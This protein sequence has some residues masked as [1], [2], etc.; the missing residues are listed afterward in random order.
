[1]DQRQK[2]WHGLWE[3][4]QVGA[5]DAITD[6]AHVFGAL[7]DV[8]TG[9]I[10]GLGVRLDRTSFKWPGQSPTAIMSFRSPDGLRPGK[11]LKPFVNKVVFNSCALFISDNLGTQI[12]GLGHIAHSEDAQIYNGFKIRD[13]PTEWVTSC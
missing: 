11:D 12:N 13:V 3:N 10:Y 2:L 5:L 6:P 4:D 9:R 7:K 8:K 1:M